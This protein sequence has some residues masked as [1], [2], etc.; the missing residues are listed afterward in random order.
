MT[1]RL[2]CTLMF[3]DCLCWP[4]DLP[5]LRGN[6]VGGPDGEEE[7]SCPPSGQQWRSEH[8]GAPKDSYP[9]G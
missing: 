2:V 9:G 1:A 6:A 4:P 8:A 7:E 3:E 5:A